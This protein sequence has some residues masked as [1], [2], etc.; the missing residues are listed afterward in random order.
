MSRTNRPSCDPPYSVEPEDR[1]GFTVRFDRFYSRAA[2]AYDLAVRF[3]PV[4]RRWLRC[5]LPHIRGPRVLEVSPGTGWLLAQY[6]RRYDAYAIDLNPS[7]L[8]ATARSLDRHDARA[9]LRIG[10]VERLPYEDGRF[11]TVVNT[12]SFSGYPDARRAMAELRRVLRPGGRLVMIDV[13]HPGD[14]NRLG[15]ALVA[16]WRL[17]GDLIRD[18]APL[19]QEFGLVATDAEIGG[20][21][22]IHLYVATVPEASPER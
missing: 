13:N 8:A 3:G 11:D 14:E 6:A 21:G 10:D 15:N 19:F 12:M 5:A 17:S 16:L 4:W 20:F 22:S 1:R 2:R 18:M 9:E 7:M